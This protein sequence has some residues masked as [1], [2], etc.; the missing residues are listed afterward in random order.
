MILLEPVG[1]HSRSVTMSFA[2][3]RHFITAGGC[4]WRYAWAVLNLEQGLT[5]L[6]FIINIIMLLFYLCHIS[7]CCTPLTESCNMYLIVIYRENNN[8]PLP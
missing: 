4:N 5:I 6:L 3:W 8:G 2:R 7:S 1:L